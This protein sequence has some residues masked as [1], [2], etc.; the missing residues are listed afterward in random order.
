MN[1]HAISI[2]SAVRLLWFK[3]LNFC[4]FFCKFMFF[5]AISAAFLAGGWGSSLREHAAEI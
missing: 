2:D 5:D 3:A 1:V 4:Y